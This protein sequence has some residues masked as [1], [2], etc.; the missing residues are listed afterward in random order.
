[1]SNLDVISAN[2]EG[3]QDRL[4]EM[5][6]RDLRLVVAESQ[7]C[8]FPIDYY[9]WTMGERGEAQQA[10]D[11][12]TELLPDIQDYANPIVENRRNL[13]LQFMSL[14]LQSGVLDQT[15]YQKL[16]EGYWTAIFD[17]F[18]KLEDSAASVY[19]ISTEFTSGNIDRARSIF[20]ESY[21][22]DFGSI[23]RWQQFLKYPWLTEFRSDPEVKQVIDEYLRD[24][25][26]QI[27]EVR[28]MLQQP[29]WQH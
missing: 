9:A 21:T 16:A 11:F 19:L 15:T 4:L 23:W 18:P 26:A 27:D 28:E 14:Y 5:L 17:H 8:Y 3:D 22:V 2:L 20:L 29:E 1:M 10:I 13:Y 25:A 7:V 24:R 6:R 12:L